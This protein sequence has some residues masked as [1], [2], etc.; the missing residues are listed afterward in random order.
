LKPLCGRGL[1][2][3]IKKIAIITGTR[4]EYGLLK[5]VMFEIQ[6]RFELQI[7]VTGMHLSKKHGLTYRYIESD[8]FK[9][10][11]KVEMDIEDD[12]NISMATSLGKGIQGLSKA[13]ED[14][15]PDVVI[16]LGDRS[17]ALAGA[18][19]GAYHNKV[20]AHIHGGEVSKGC[21]DESIRHAIT[22]FAHIHFP[23]S[24][25]SA[26]RIKRMGERPEYIYNV[27]A[28]G[29]DDIR[30][31]KYTSI[32]KIYSKYSL[33]KKKPTILVIQ[34]PVTQEPNKAKTQMKL[35]LEALMDINA[36]YILI[37]PNNDAG[38]RA[39]IDIIESTKLPKN[40]STYQNIPRVDFLGL[41]SI[42]S[43]IV[44]N[45]SSGIIEAPSFHLPAIN[46]GIR[47]EG[48]LKAR[49]VIDVPHDKQEI[50]KAI[51]RAITDKKFQSELKTIK[52][53]Y[54][55]GKASIRIVKIIEDL[56][57][58]KELIQKQITY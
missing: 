2:I 51:R 35:T 8:G 21:I 50:M 20:V 38:G 39:M 26:N 42:A 34:H 37:Y 16:I 13:L 17:E 5:P 32:N 29:L 22:K 43:C 14:L 10:N 49:N 58:T 28:P 27:G 40:F 7:I 25:D 23:A 18:I 19:V 54:G 33:T 45:S 3:I 52:N 15:D 12:T 1:R 36:N 53:P 47:Q 44:G 11:K 46:I 24:Q 56:E 57:I 4:A 41:M 55:D 6:K 31:K 9:I 30:E 48:R